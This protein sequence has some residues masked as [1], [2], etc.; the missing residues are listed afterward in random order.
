MH[1][2]VFTRQAENQLLALFMHIASVASPE[3]ASGYT[4]DCAAM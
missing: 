3:I 2:V 4:D 1:R